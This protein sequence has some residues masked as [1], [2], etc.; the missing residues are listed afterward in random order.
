MS[1]KN[2]YICHVVIRRS[3]TRANFEFF[4]LCTTIIN[5]L[6]RYDVFYVDVLVNII[7]RATQKVYDFT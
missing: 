6:I 3:E 4:P 5:I 1:I 7:Q 2:N